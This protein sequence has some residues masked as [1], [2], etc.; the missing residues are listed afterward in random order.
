MLSNPVC[1]LPSLLISRSCFHVDLA[2]ITPLSL[3]VLQ[4]MLQQPLFSWMGRRILA[5]EEEHN[6]AGSV[7]LT[8]AHPVFHHLIIGACGWPIKRI[9]P[10]HP[11]NILQTQHVSSNDILSMFAAVGPWYNPCGTPGR[12]LPKLT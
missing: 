7:H 11:T 4:T 5:L 12:G 9:Q 1:G 6:G 10:A 8:L 2:C 3:T